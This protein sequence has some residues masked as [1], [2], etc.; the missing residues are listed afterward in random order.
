MWN[1]TIGSF[2]WTQ[3][4]GGNLRKNEHLRLVAQSML[5]R[6]TKIP[7]R[8]LRKIGI[9]RA[10]VACIDLDSIR[11]PDTRA[12]RDAFELCA[13][14]SPIF[15]VNHCMRTYLWGAL[16]AAGEGLQ[17][18]EELFYV[19]SLLHDL[20]LTNTCQRSGNCSCFAAAGA[21]AAQ[22]FA[23]SHQWPEP[24]QH[25]LADAISMHLNMQVTKRQGMEAHLLHEGASLDVIGA[26]FSQIHVQNKTEVL[27]R[28]PRARFKTQMIGLMKGEA[29][30]HSASRAGF[31]V[32]MGLNH[33][34]RAAPFAE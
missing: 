14:T 8:G 15:L 22:Q 30:T 17:Y 1:P 7:A 23:Q 10:A 32:D 24:K 12:A 9:S 26:R 2:K 28:Y 19:A 18:D 33:L 20:G 27:D 29:K 11:I 34:I 25:A 3:V 5:Q 21:K 31:L 16:L 6:L 13:E 4:T